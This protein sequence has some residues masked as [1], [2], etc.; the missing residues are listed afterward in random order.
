METYASRQS[1]GS[2]LSGESR[3]SRYVGAALC[4]TATYRGSMVR[5]KE[6]YFSD[7]KCKNLSR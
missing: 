5:I 3:G 7:G 1:L 4:P 6:L 2:V